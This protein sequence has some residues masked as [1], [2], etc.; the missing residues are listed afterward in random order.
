MVPQILLNT[1]RVKQFRVDPRMSASIKGLEE[2]FIKF[3]VIIQTSR[4]RTITD[5]P[6][7]IQSLGKCGIGTRG[8]KVHN[9]QFHI[10]AKYY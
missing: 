6:G 5:L 3:T 4:G 9:L 2:L 7:S 8:Q 1:K 10:S